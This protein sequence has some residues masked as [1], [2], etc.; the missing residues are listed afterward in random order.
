MCECRRQ[1]QIDASPEAG[2][3]VTEQQPTGGDLAEAGKNQQGD[4]VLT[5]Y[6]LLFI[7]IIL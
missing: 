4:Q 7:L 1:P 5:N 3:V 2:T 6:I